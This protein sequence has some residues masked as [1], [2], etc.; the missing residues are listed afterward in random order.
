MIHGPVAGKLR[1]KDQGNRNRISFLS[2]SLTGCGKAEVVPG[3]GIGLLPSRLAAAARI[4]DCNPH[5]RRHDVLAHFAED[6]GAG[7]VHLHQRADTLRGSQAQHG[8]QLRLSYGIAIE[9][10]HVELMPGKTNPGPSGGLGFRILK[11]TCWPALTRSGSPKP[12]TRPLM[13]E[14][15]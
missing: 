10:D 12:N 4:L 7:L 9:R 2:G 13:V 3:K 8:H 11:N 5:A 1:C 14:T 6:P 15:L